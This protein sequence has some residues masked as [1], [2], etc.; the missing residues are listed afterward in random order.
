MGTGNH[1]KH[2]SGCPPKRYKSSSRHTAKQ[3]QLEAQK[4]SQ[5]PPEESLAPPPLSFL[6][7]TVKEL[8]F[9]HLATQHLGVLRFLGPAAPSRDTGRLFL[10]TVPQKL[11]AWKFLGSVNTIELPYWFDMQVRS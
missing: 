8:L 10:D 7:L 3:A 1:L 4:R 5:P 11:P 6:K 2:P 9:A